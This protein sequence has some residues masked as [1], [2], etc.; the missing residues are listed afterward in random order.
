MEKLFL[1][2]G[3]VEGFVAA[4]EKKDL[5]TAD[6]SRRVAELSRRVAEKMLLDRQECGKIHM[7]AYVHDIGKIAVPDSI[8]NKSERLTGPE[9]EIMKKH[10]EM[11]ADILKEFP[12]MRSL[13]ELVL[14]HHERVDGGGYPNGLKGEE[15]PL[16]SRIIAVCD[17]VD[18]MKS[19]RAYR[20]P[21]SDTV[22]R[23]EIEKNIGRMYD[24]AVAGLILANWDAIVSNEYR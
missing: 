3:I 16:G 19:L 13:S 23:A 11:G 6:H 7:A 4:L 24:G 14:C 20:A 2:G 17:S 5:Y 15:I 1:Y 18:A 9:W 8:L 12:A 10:P 21:F 22:C